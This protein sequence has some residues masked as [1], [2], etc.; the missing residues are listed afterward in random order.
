MTDL[1]LKRALE[2]YTQ[3]GADREAAAKQELLHRLVRCSAPRRLPWVVAAVLALTLSL[4]AFTPPGRAL[5]AELGQ[6]VA[7]LIETLFPPKDVTVAPEGMEE[8]ITHTPHGEEPASD[9]SGAALPGFVIYADEENYT[10]T[11]EDGLMRIEPKN[12]PQ[13]RGDDGAPVPPCCLTVEHRPELS[14]SAAGDTLAAELEQRYAQ[15]EGPADSALL[16]GGLF[17]RGSDGTNWDDAQAEVHITQDG[18]G[19]VYV[20]TAQYFTEA[21][22][23]HGVRFSAM[24]ATFQLVR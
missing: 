23:G 19:G 4:A 22:E 15:V 6:A 10:I 11:E 14:L 21:A 5:S 9:P 12:P 7:G 24:I 3:A 13:I 18:T 20:L 17:L 8:T 1:D 2:R 16:S